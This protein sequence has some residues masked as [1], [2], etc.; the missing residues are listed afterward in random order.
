[1]VNHGSDRP[2]Q[3]RRNPRDFGNVKGPEALSTSVGR[4]VFRGFQLGFQ[5]FLRDFDGLDHLNTKPLRLNRSRGA[6]RLF[7]MINLLLLQV[8]ETR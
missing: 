6:P 5:R 3:H 7:V 2:S 8:G 4:F 1:M